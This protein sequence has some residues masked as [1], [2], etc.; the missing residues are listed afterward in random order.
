MSIETNDRLELI[1]DLRHAVEKEQLVLHYQPQMDI[2]LGALV[3]AEALLRWDHPVRGLVPPMDFIPDAE[4]TG[5]IVPVGEWVLRTACAQVR[6]WHEAGFP[7]IRIGI[8]L[9]PVQLRRQGL[10]ATVAKVLK[11]VQLEP[12]YVDLELTESILMHNT[13]VSVS[14]LLDLRAL[15][16]SLSIDDFGTGYSSLSYLR[17][18]PVDTLKIDRTF[19][20]DVDKGGQAAVI[21]EAV[22]KLGHRLGMRVLAEGVETPGQLDYLRTLGCD[23]AQ[24]FYFSRPVP[25]E[26]FAE[27]LVKGVEAPDH[28]PPPLTLEFY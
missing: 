23:L 7:P 13:K 22:I 15:G 28:K 17:Q 14:A 27:L 18:F 20:A 21:A 10:T 24:G 12:C 6:A 4:T 11:Q 2:R 9:S 19:V 5:L 25:A 8:N 16:V 26:E 1:N 3:G